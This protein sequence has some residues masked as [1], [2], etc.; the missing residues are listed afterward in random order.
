L[1]DRLFRRISKL[2][3]AGQTR[4]TIRAEVGDTTGSQPVPPLT[5]TNRPEAAAAGQRS[6][7]YFLAT[8]AAEVS[9]W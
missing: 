7:R 1:L 6:R 5:P 2:T 9:Y 4:T 3:I 8:L